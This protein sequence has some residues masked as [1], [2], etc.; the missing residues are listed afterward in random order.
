MKINDYYRTILVGLFLCFVNFVQAGGNGTGLL[1]RMKKTSFEKILKK[2]SENIKKKRASADILQFYGNG[3]YEKITECRGKAVEYQREYGCFV[4]VGNCRKDGNI[5]TGMYSFVPRYSARSIPYAE[6]GIDSLC[7]LFEKYDEYCYVSGNRK[8]FRFIRALE[9]WGPLFGD[10]ANYE[11]QQVSSNGGTLTFQFETRDSCYPYEIPFYCVGTLVLDRKTC[12]LKNIDIDQVEYYC[13]DHQEWKEM[14]LKEVPLDS[15]AVVEFGY[16]DKGQC[17]IK[18]CV[19]ESVW[20]DVLLEK[21]SFT[22][23]PSRK[24][25]GKN[26]LIEKEAFSSVTCQSVSKNMQHEDLPPALMYSVCNPQGEYVSEIFMRLPELLDAKQAFIDLSNDVDIY[27]Q[28]R[29]MSNHPYYPDDFFFVLPWC[30][31]ADKD[32]KDDFWE[33]SLKINK[34]ILLLFFN[35]M[36]I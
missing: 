1:P 2:A 36:K 25:P 17:F 27:E 22:D 3:Q 20:K 33:N 21:W 35:K 13:C 19:L 14:Y 32:L 18:S 9:W 26:R 7:S 11:F 10:L 30:T 5:Y 12:E 24:E 34:F 29:Q 15:R 8:I 16:D 4:K 31:E 6:N 28:F 23:A